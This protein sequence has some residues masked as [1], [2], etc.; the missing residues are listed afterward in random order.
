VCGAVHTVWC[1]V[2]TWNDGRSTSSAWFLVG[3]DENPGSDRIPNGCRIQILK[4]GV[5]L[6][7]FFGF[8]DS[9]PINRNLKLYA[10]SRRTYNRRQVDIQARKRYGKANAREGNHTFRVQLCV[11][12]GRRLWIQANLPAIPIHDP[13]P[14][15]GPRATVTKSTERNNETGRNKSR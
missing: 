12:A 6:S 13:A 11:T 15:A 10:G 7:F 2:R 5:S 14:L 3:V 1:G 4:Q 9:T 8:G